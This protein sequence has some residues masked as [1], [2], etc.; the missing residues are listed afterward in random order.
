MAASPAEW[1][2]NVLSEE[3][4]VSTATRLASNFVQIE[5]AGKSGFVAGVLSE[6][7]V[8][9]EAVKP[10]LRSNLRPS[11][12][13]NIPRETVWTGEAITALQAE[14]IAFGGVSDLRRAVHE[15]DPRKYVFKEYAYVERRLRQHRIVT[16]LDRLYDR[17]WR[18]HRKGGSALDIAISNE[19]DLTA[20]EVRTIHDRYG[21]VD[22]IFH[23]NSM[24]RQTDGACIAA[25]ELDIELVASGDLFARLGQ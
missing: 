18:V 13:I 20:D 22:I 24:G 23:T 6:S 7:V 10:F 17:V 19:Y 16:K 25:Q 11:F 4:E 8:T 14:S 9:Y 3:R 1:I 21:S 2:S 12:V 5:R 15:S